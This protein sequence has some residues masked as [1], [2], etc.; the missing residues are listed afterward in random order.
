MIHLVIEKEALTQSLVIAGYEH[1][2]LGKVHFGDSR[3][4]QEPT[5][6]PSYVETEKRTHSFM[7]V[8]CH[9]HPPFQN[10]SGDQAYVPV[11]PSFHNR[12]HGDTWGKQFLG[13]FKSIGWR[14]GRAA[15]MATELISAREAR[16]QDGSW[17][18]QHPMQSCGTQVL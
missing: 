7:T 17:C 15:A 1:L 2:V 4:L 8:L 14:L 9:W 12:V 16:V 3:V 10:A 11:L 13:Q 5:V 18:R 6:E